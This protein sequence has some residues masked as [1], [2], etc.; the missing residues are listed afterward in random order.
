MSRGSRLRAADRPTCTARRRPRRTSRPVE[1][2]TAPA[3]RAG[4]P[5]PAPAAPSA[6]AGATA[7]VS[8][9]RR[10]TARCSVQ[11]G[12]VARTGSTI[13]PRVP[14]PRGRGRLPSPPLGRSAGDPHVRQRARRARVLLRAGRHVPLGAA[15]SRPQPR[16]AQLAA[17][18]DG[19]SSPTIVTSRA[20]PG[21][22]VIGEQPAGAGPV[23]PVS[24]ARATRRA[25]TIGDARRAAA[26]RAPTGWP[27]RSPRP[28]AAVSGRAVVQRVVELGRASRAVAP[29]VDV[30]P[31]GASHRRR[32][33]A[34]GREPSGRRLWV[35]RP[36]QRPG[37]RGGPR[38]RREREADV[39]SSGPRTEPGG[40][41][42]P[43]P[44]PRP[45]LG[46]RSDVV[47]R[48]CLRRDRRRRHGSQERRS[49]FALP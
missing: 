34:P 30:D 33:V 49:G 18:S 3:R 14:R 37:S 38:Q 31:R 6:G 35:R 1:R 19:E 44:G 23:E 21:L 41:S 25:S 45:A 12:S 22:P 8:V 26:S 32:L 4:A 43:V 15:G 39:G 24:A 2:P 48:P 13:A 36:G 11:G 20:Q 27:Q 42:S 5:R 40:G 10:A 28:G 29:A 9:V 16:A 17:T 46:E 47:H 7:G